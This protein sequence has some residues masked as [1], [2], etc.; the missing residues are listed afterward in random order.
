MRPNANFGKPFVSGRAYAEAETALGK[1][2]LKSDGR[3][4]AIEHF[5]RALR[6]NPDTMAAQYG[7]A[8]ALRKENAPLRPVSLCGKWPSYLKSLIKRCEVTA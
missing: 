8:Q 1:L 7:L 5:K 4:E 3:L 6:S 2:L